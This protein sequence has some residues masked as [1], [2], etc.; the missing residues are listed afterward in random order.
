[1]TRVLVVGSN[2]ML[3]HDLLEVLE[4][5]GR[6]RELETYA[7]DLPETDITDPES[8]KRCFDRVK[9]QTVFNCAAYTDVDGCETRRELA[10]AVNGAGPGNLARAAASGALLVHV[11]TDFVF[12]GAKDGAYLE[13][14]EPRP[15]NVYGESKLEGE[16]QVKSLARDF[17]I[18][19]TAWLFGV[20]GRSFPRS[21]LSQARSSGRLKVVDDQRGSPTHT[22]DLA[23]MMW[24][25]VEVN[26]RGL[27]HAAGAG[28]CTWYELAEEVCRQAGCSVR[29]DPITSDQLG[30]AARR[31]ANSV[32]DS[33]RATEQTGFEFPSW[34]RSLGVFL[35]RL[36]L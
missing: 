18:V 12:D 35:D 11:S 28:S 21:I 13:E 20:H 36:G 23:R 19:R 25:L 6:E 17:L 24:K 9:P 15:L 3:A 4:E 34:R 14:D 29:I 32:L 10:M 30:R 26:A 27:R 5:A 22:L 7:T 2:G 8:V 1:M 31:P 16:R 33:S